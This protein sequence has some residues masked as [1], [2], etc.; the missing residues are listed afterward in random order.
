MAKRKRNPKTVLSYNQRYYAENRDRLLAQTRLRRYG[1]TPEAFDA[2]LEEQDG[3][4]AICVTPFED[5][6]DMRIDHDHACCPGRTTCGKCIR[7]I[8]CH[9][10]NSGLGYFNDDPARIRAAATYL[11]GA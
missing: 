3:A 8:L 10:C 11:A 2:M 1:L 6:R 9:R 4:C 7:G 5:T